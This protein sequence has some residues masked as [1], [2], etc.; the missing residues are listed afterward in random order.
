MASTCTIYSVHQPPVPLLCAG[1]CL[2]CVGV[3]AYCA[4]VVVISAA[5]PA[6]S[7]PATAP[8][9]SSNATSAFFS[10]SN[11]FIFYF[12]FFSIDSV[13]HLRHIPPD[14]LNLF[15]VENFMILPCF[16]L[17]KNQTKLKEIPTR[18]G[19]DRYRC[20]CS[21]GSEKKCRLII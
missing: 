5:I 14:A 16:A 4:G 3:C 13:V 10:F 15:P 11:N 9:Q 19:S 1:F 20:L 8:C 18:L 7:Y 2:W 17:N 12:F 21:S 6:G